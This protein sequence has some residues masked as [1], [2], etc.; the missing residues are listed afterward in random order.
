MNRV[1]RTV[2]CWMLVVSMVVSP[3]LVYAQQ[4]AA[5]ST[6]AAEGE[7]L[8]LS[9]VTPEALL[10]A[11]AR[12]RRVLTAPQMEMLPI[13]V[14]SA[15][16]KKELG[17]DPLDV[18]Q[19]MVIVEAPQASPPGFGAVIR[20]SKPYQLEDV[21]MPLTA[22]TVEGDLEGTPYRQGRTPSDPSLYMPDEQTLLVATDFLLRKI[23]ANRK[24][25]AEGPLTKLLA[26]T[27]TSSDFFAIATIDPVREM[28][29]A[30]LAVVPV[31]PPLEGL[32]RLP[33][34]LTAAKLELVVTGT[35]GVSLVLLTP[36]EAAA[37]RL[38]ELING[39][40]DFG[41][42][43]A[44]AQITQQISGDDPVEQAMLQYLERINERMVET[45]RPARKGSVVKLSQG[46]GQYTQTATVGILAAVLLPAVQAAREAARRSHSSNN[47]KQI[48]LAMHNY[49]DA[50]GRFPARANF[51]DGGTPLLSWRVHIL[52][53]VEQN[54][55]YEQFHL[56]EP[57]DS[58]HNMTLIPFMPQLYRNPSSTAG[59]GK[60]T[61]LVPVGEG[62]TFGAQEGSALKDVTDGSSNTI[63]ALEVNDDEAVI[64]TKPQ[65]WQ[66]D[67]DRPLAGLGRAH[68]GGFEVLF[69]DGSVHFLAGSIDPDVL[70]RLLT[71]ADGEAVSLP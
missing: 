1:G 47:L 28:L 23:V 8:D 36:D 48:G 27:D 39:L 24:A 40:L 42:Q 45:L 46:G 9:Y 52:P 29:S 58:Q 57:W 63:M 44:L 60:A 10:A 33:E 25:P 59:P 62:T 43:M 14:F 3:P 41:R 2:L 49:H 31:P 15:A 20:F 12:P 51:D 6:A 38:E 22:R 5:G 53:Y 37:E 70:R 67:P 68:P 32:K 17:I 11:A 18:E 50:N 61:Y 55:L 65:D 26:A 35:V 56:D 71:M 66:Y 64:W 7:T 21:M 54:P 16:G 69:A 13:E 19:V 34:L 30:Q 4:P